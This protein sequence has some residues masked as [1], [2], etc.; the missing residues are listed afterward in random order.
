MQMHDFEQKVSH[1]V[2]I[3]EW[4]KKLGSKV[5][6]FELPVIGRFIAV[7]D[8]ATVKYIVA[9][10]NFPKSPTYQ[11]MEPLIGKN[12]ILVTEGEKWSTQRR[13]YRPGFSPDFLRNVVDVIVQKTNRSLEQCDKDVEQGIVTNIHARAIALTID[14]IAQ[15]AFGEDWGGDNPTVHTLRELVDEVAENMVNPMRRIFNLKARWRTR[16]LSKTLNRDM[17][18][19]VERRLR[20]LEQQQTS[21]SNGSCGRQQKDILSWTLMADTREGTAIS[22]EEMEEIISQLKSFYFAGH[23]TTATIIAWSVWLLAQ[24]P[25]ALKKVRSEL[26]A[27][28]G[29]WAAGLASHNTGN[30]KDLP[31]PAFEA[32]QRCSYLEAVVKEVLRLYPPASSTRIIADP[33]VEFGDYHL[34]DSLVHICTYAIHRDPDYWDE[35]DSF[36]PE[37]FLEES[38]CSTDYTYLPFSRGPRDCMGQYFATLEAKIVVASFILRYDAVV[39]DIKEVY[40]AR[41]TSVP[42]NGC[43]V[44]FSCR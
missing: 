21:A 39:E 35:P 43:K 31:V 13:R 30:I 18:S 32:L 19:L 23:D 27:E 15:V 11:I 8:P 36:I 7:A 37:R 34:G 6:Q 41:L 25:E 24:H 17:K 4:M 9:T 38:R 40:S 1:D 44:K 14:V 2:L 33:D 22:A 16:R 10:K 28:L 26:E 12:G 20:E 42:K 5:V 3:F 29:E